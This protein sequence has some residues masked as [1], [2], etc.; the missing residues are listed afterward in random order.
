MSFHVFITD[1]G[2]GDD[3][4]ER[5]MLEEQGYTVTNLQ[6]RDSDILRTSVAEADALLVQWAPVDSSVIEMLDRCRVIVRYGIG[7]DNVDIP[8][9]TNKGI[10]VCNVPDYCIDEVADHT[11]ALALSLGRQ[12]GFTDSLVRE[13]TWRIVPPW[14]M[15]AFRKMLFVT[16]GFGRI[17]REVLR[18][19][20]SFEFQ[21]AA[22]DP[23]VPESEMSK[24][25]VRKLSMEEALSEADILSLHLPL[26]ASTH[27]LISDLNLRKMKKEA[28]LINTSR[29]GLIDTYALADALNRKVIFAAGVDVFETEPVAADHP[30]LRCDNALL[31]SHTAWYS[32]SSVPALRRMATEEVIRGL[33]GLPLKNIIR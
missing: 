17:A 9:A 25:N 10:P 30:L 6:C 15:A 7:V 22:C 19:A 28:I 8:A 29:G 14:P 1:S 27:H 24:Y 3:N 5:A 33:K 11:M 2:F 32:E 31:T 16:F 23:L 18:R 4:I 21:L 12:L 13:G 20:A 26:N